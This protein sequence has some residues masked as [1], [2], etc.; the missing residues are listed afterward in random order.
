MISTTQLIAKN[1]FK[2]VTIFTLLFLFSI[3]L[4]FYFFF[5]LIFF[6]GTI[7]SI[8][9]HRNPERELVEYD[10][11]GITAPIDGFISNIKNNDDNIILSIDNKFTD[12]HIL[13]IPLSSKI[14]IIENINGIS[15]P[16]LN[17]K[18]KKL[19]SRIFAKFDKNIDIEIIAGKCGKK[20]YLYNFK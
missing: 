11:L 6:I 19:N 14:D 4:D 9:T 20:I 13:R 15:L 1:G 12:N 7:C 16:I 5:K 2:I 3:L 18:S 17:R 10:E 8:Y